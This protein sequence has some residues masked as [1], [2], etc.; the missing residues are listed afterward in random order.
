MYC[1]LWSPWCRARNLR[2]MLRSKVIVTWVICLLNVVVLWDLDLFSNRSCP[3]HKTI[4][5]LIFR[6]KSQ[7]LADIWPTAETISL[8]IKESIKRKMNCRIFQA[9]VI[10][11]SLSNKRISCF[12]LFWTFKRRHWGQIE[13]MI[14]SFINDYLFDF[15]LWGLIGSGTIW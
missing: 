4:S 7:I 13:K 8:L 15:V 2:K 1:N 3:G 12:S 10:G 9:W 11:F 6:K 5:F 14:G